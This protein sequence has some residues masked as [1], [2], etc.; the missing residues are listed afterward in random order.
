MNHGNSISEGTASRAP[1]HNRRLGKV[2]REVDGKSA[3]IGGATGVCQAGRMAGCGNWVAFIR[4]HQLMTQGADIAQLQDH[5]ARQFALHIEVE[6]VNIR[7]G[8]VGGI[9]AD[10]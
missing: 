9:G 10:R 6:V 4:P 3:S 8:V 2:L 5:V 1:G 7:D